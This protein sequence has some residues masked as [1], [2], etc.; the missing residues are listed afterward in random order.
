MV[1]HVRHLDFQVLARDVRLEPI[2]TASYIDRNDADHSFKATS[3][4]IDR[5][6]VTDLKGSRNPTSVRYH[7]S[8]D[9]TDSKIM[10]AG[11]VEQTAE[12]S[13]H[14]VRLELNNKHARSFSL[15]DR[16]RF[17]EAPIGIH[18]L[19]SFGRHLD[20]DGSAIG[21][22]AGRDLVVRLTPILR[23]GSKTNMEAQCQTLVEYH[24]RGYRRDFIS[25][26]LAAQRHA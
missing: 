13:M 6:P 15:H 14:I 9:S 19:D 26:N 7:S 25:R 21:P 22:L 12:R 5:A 4:L 8:A 11:L 18:A 16:A 23:G 20:L 17:S 1:G 10:N 24:G 2:C 3:D